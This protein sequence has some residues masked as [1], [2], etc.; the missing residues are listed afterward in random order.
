MEVCFL[1]TCTQSWLGTS[2]RGTRT[3]SGR[4]SRRARTRPT[5]VCAP[6]LSLLPPP[7]RPEKSDLATTLSIYAERITITTISF[8][9]LYFKWVIYSSIYYVIIF[10]ILKLKL[11]ITPR[12]VTV[13]SLDNDNY[14]SNYSGMSSDDSAECVGKRYVKQNNRRCRS[15]TLQLYVTLIAFHKHFLLHINLEIVKCQHLRI[16]FIILFI[17]I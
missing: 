2:G 3:H 14:Q 15:D 17:Y 4:I 13:T 10:N 1:T 6:A 9:T 8:V 5:E 16:Q 11:W 7:V 12:L